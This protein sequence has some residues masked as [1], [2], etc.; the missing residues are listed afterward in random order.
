MLG[1]EKQKNAPQIFL[2]VTLCSADPSGCVRAEAIS[3]HVENPQLEEQGGAKEAT[4][5]GEGMGQE[6][7]IVCFTPTSLSVCFLM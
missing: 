2:F 4:R 5:N 1:L 3:G 6:W 7:L